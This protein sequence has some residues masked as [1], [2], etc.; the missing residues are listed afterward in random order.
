MALCRGGQTDKLLW[1]NRATCPLFNCYTSIFYKRFKLLRVNI[2]LV[3]FSFMFFTGCTES[4]TDVVNIRAK[5]LV[6]SDVTPKGS[7]LLLITDDKFHFNEIENASESYLKETK[8]KMKQLLGKET[9]RTTSIKGVCT[10]I[11]NEAKA[12]KKYGKDNIDLLLAHEIGHCYGTLLN[13]ACDSTKCSQPTK[14]YKEYIQE[15]FA[16][17]IG[18][19]KLAKYTDNENAFK[20]KI[21][22]NA[23]R[24]YKGFDYR[25]SEKTLKL[26][27][28]YF[29]SDKVYTDQKLAKLFVAGMCTNYEF[30]QGKCISSK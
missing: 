16:D 2:F 27:Q 5:V 4:K 7:E 30:S 23:S 17:F 29:L 1:N 20:D 8:E 26:A 12:L 9:A 3:L 11:V 10:I 28:S 14:E 19:Y 6:S 15:S 13:E 21:S 24:K 25:N 22:I 18:V